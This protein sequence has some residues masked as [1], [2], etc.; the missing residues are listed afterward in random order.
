MSA[1][2]HMLSSRNKT[3]VNFPASKSWLDELI[4]TIYLSMDKS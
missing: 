1:P 2:K 4:L 3:N